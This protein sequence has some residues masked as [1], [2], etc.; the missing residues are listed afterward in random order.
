[1]AWHRS[2]R[3]WCCGEAMHCISTRASFFCCSGAFSGLQLEERGGP[4]CREGCKY[5]RHYAV[6]FKTNTHT[7][8]KPP[9]PPPQPNRAKCQSP[10]AYTFKRKTVKAKPFVLAILLQCCCWNDG[11]E[12]SSSQMEKPFGYSMPKCGEALTRSNL[13]LAM[14]RTV[15]SI[16]AVFFT[17]CH[18]ES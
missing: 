11:R 14:R 10:R 13:N 12:R 6:F 4:S 1:M 16:S 3:Y 5:S 8:S 9:P 18:L 2:V 15:L 7:C 17:C